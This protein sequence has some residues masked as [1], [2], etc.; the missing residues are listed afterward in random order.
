MASFSTLPLT[1]LAAALTLGDHEL[2]SL[3]GGGGKTTALFA[4]GRQ[5]PGS[6]LLTTTTK[7]GRSRT[8]GYPVL[9]GAD[10][11][12]LGDALADGGRVLVWGGGEDEKALGI[13]PEACDRWFAAGH[14]VV[15]EADGSRRKP[16]KA[17]R[18]YEPVLPSG[19]T[20]LVACVGAAALDAPIDEGCQRPEL[21]AGLVGCGE[22]D[23]LTPDRL[24]TV[25][26]SPRGSAKDRP[27]GAR[28]A[29][30]INQATDHHAVFL[31]EL[32]ARLG[33]EV[34]LSAVRPFGPGESPEG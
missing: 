2:V 26:T 27:A 9:V 30:V 13:A 10:D 1:D 16:F 29:V 17:P 25:L 34:P 24:A 21:V 18:P 6:V 14:N 23:P 5:L 28:F 19:T 32:A 31:E 8:G 33:P 11:E 7:M 20:F 3:V 12:A 4:L 22:G 15:V